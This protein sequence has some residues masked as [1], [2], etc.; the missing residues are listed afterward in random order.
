MSDPVRLRWGLAGTSGFADAV[1]APVLRNAGQELLGAAGSSPHGSA[2]FAVRHGTPRTYASLDALLGDPEVEAVWI[3]SP[4]HLHEEHVRLALAAGKHVL[5]EKPLATTGSGAQALAELAERVDR[6]LAVGYQGRFHPALHD[7]WRRVQ[8]GALG[9]VA[10]VRASW[11]TQYAGLPG[12]WRL[13]R[14]TSGGW[15]IMDIGTHTLDAALWLTGFPATTL[16]GSRLSNQH[17]PVDVEDLA[18]LLLQVGNATAVVEAAT[19]VQG[20]V[21]RVEVH[22]TA[23]WA[24]ASGVFVPRLGVAGGRLRASD[25]A[26]IAYDTAPN[27]YETQVTAFAAWTADGAFVGATGAEGAANIAL[28]E[29]ARDEGDR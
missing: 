8:D 2:A 23:G 12:S 11:Q 15:A 28:L 27:P 4:N 13:R 19:G 18:V 20:P 14:D 22:G 16:I 6:R 24:I 10:F 17:W 21:N 29:A 25:G 7:L 26:H 5:A 3:A 9:E 1:F